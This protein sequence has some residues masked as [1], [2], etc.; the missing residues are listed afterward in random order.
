MNYFAYGSNMSTPRLRERV[1]SCEFVTTAKLTEHQLR[2]HKRSSDNS[3]KCDAFH[4]G[5]DTDIIWG[6]VFNIP[7]AEK[8][9]LDK[10][11]GL[12]KGY[13]EKTVD[14]ITPAGEHLRAITYYADRT[15]VVEGLSPY[16][17]YKDLV[18]NGAIEH[19][20]PADYLAAS[21]ETISAT[22]DPDANRD[23]RNRFG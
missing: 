7:I 3:S 1:P 22:I 21:I 20:L 8:K 4:T 9:A 12:G 14:L 17:W 13:N 5:I 6:A 15:A 23:R 2:F 19:G 18:L 10:A 16:T 11:E